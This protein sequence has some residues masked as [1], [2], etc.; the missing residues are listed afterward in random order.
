M[1][2]AVIQLAIVIEFVLAIDLTAETA[3]AQGHVLLAEH[4]FY[5]L[6]EDLH[7]LALC[8]VERR[9]DDGFLRTIFQC[10]IDRVNVVL[11]EAVDGLLVLIS[12]VSAGVVISVFFLN[13]FSLL[14][15]EKLEC[16]IIV[17]KPWMSKDLFNGQSL[18]RIDLQ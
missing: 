16:I 18:V 4:G 11:G 5:L 9:Q 17:L 15:I 10:V 1:I 6:L 3:Q 14:I 13:H 12:I 8:R 2:D 7:I